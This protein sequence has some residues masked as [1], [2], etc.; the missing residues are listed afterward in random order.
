MEDAVSMGKMR[1]I[2][3][4]T[5][6]QVIVLG[7]LATPQAAR[8]GGNEAARKHYDRATELADD[9]QPEAAIVEFQRF[10]DLTHQF[11][12]LYDIGQVYLSL[13]KPVEAVDAY[14]RYLA[15][16]GKRVPAARRAEVEKEIERQNA[17]IATVR[18][19]G[20][21][22][23]AVVRLDGKEIAKAPITAPVRVGMGTHTIAASA[24]GYE[25]A[26]IE[27]ELVGEDRHVVELVLAKHLVETPSRRLVAPMV[28]TPPHV[29]P[30]S[31][32]LRAAPM[33]AEPAPALPPAVPSAPMAAAAVADLPA[34]V[35][36]P[37]ELAPPMVPPVSSQPPP[38]G[39]KVAAPSVASPLPVTKPG[40]GLR[41]AG[42]VCGATA[43]ASV[44]AGVF[45]GFETRAHSNS[46]QSAPVYN[47]AYAARGRLYED[48]QWTAF[49][50]GAGLAVTGALLYAIGAASSSAP[51]VALV[52]LPAGA[53]VSA[54]GTF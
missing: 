42:L 14:Q 25:P 40:R 53:G 48:L 54:E 18:I 33:A 23:G 24:E 13:A 34:S 20:L 12:V 46:A 44:G 4:Q 2:A 51:A 50:V 17:R 37:A 52:P 15:D 7:A 29:S 32:P 22:Q 36:V 45:F 35:G 19:R 8:A 43:I 41:M 31:P 49:G 9:G 11:A 27:I 39:V 1:S 16:G 3:R 26:K 5:A 10:Y 38:A 28:G 6:L 30:V 47:S 21:P